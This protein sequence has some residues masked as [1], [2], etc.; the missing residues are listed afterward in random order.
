MQV[1]VTGWGKT[2]L[3]DFETN[4]VLKE[5]RLKSVSSKDCATLLFRPITT[6]MMCAGDMTGTHDSCSVSLF[7]DFV[8]V[9]L[10]AYILKIF[11]LP[12]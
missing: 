2:S 4:D 9:S 8:F 11:L 7:S 6:H 5:A 3:Y 1:V 12:G 10:K